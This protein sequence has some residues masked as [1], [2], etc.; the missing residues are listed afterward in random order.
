MR[1]TVPSASVRLFLALA[2]LALTAR[3]ARAG[4]GN[5]APD[6]R[7]EWAGVELLPL[8]VNAG[9]VRS[10][11]TPPPRFRAGLGVMLRGPRLLW[12]NVYWTPLEAGGFL[13]GSG[14]GAN[15]IVL[16]QVATE[17]GLRLPVGPGTFELGLGAG[18][19]GLSID[20][21][22]TCDGTCAIGGVGP[23]LSPVVRYLLDAG[24][25]SVGFVVRGAVP[26]RVPHGEW[27]ST[28]TGFGA[29]VTAGAEVAFG[30]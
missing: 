28:I 16:M 12:T 6:M 7:F 11:E 29:L 2:V 1:A 27:L 30:S 18:L 17:A 22:T 5:P 4:E 3:G 26:L 19:G 24:R 15:R 9:S 25:W 23:M 14:S 21:G 8:S 20:Y 13:S 10:W